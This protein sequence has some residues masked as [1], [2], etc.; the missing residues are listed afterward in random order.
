MQEPKQGGALKWLVAI[1]VIAIIVLAVVMARKNKGGETA[2]TTEVAGDTY[3]IG[4]LL[5]LTGDA[6]AYGEI[7]R[8]AEQIAFDEINNAG[9]INGKK[10]EPIFEDGRCNGQDAT[11]AMQKLVNVD[12]VQ[13][14]A[15]GFC[16]SESIA[17][18]AIANTS[19]VLLLS[20]GSS[21]P[22]LTGISHFFFR[23]YPSDAT[24]GQVLADISYNKEGFKKV[25]FIQEQQD[26]ALGIYQA[27]SDEFQK[28]GGKVVKE[29]YPKEAADFRSQL[30]KLKSENPD[31]LFLD[32]QTPAAAQRI[33]KQLQDLNWKPRL[34]MSDQN[35]GDSELLSG[36]KAFLEGALVAEFGVDENN[37]K[38]KQLNESYK[39]KYGKE[40]DFKSYTQTVYDSIYII[41]D[42]ITAVGY[43]GQKLADW[44]RTIKDWPGASDFVTIQDNG[45]RAS[46]HKPEI[47]KDGKTVPYT[48]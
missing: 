30:V 21:S 44:S 42:G 16:S 39:Q 37:P 27:F 10:L 43:D 24:Q 48:K 20:G 8:N 6:A 2:G 7:M 4:V 46:G 3:K 22:K 23:N 29:E 32:T 38:F 47:I 41:K 9:G 14:V 45:D 28:L 31:A 35:A 34:L 17:A 18:A 5:P 11:N 25:A 26:Y 1:F 15:G 33:V 40:M 12:H 13:V 19:K 36:N